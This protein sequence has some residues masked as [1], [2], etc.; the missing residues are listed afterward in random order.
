[1]V[2]VYL[3]RTKVCRPP[4]LKECMY[5]VSGIVNPNGHFSKHIW[6]GAGP[7]GLQCTCELRWYGY[8]VEIITSRTLS[9]RKTLFALN[10]TNK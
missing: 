5:V 2:T 9:V 7:E 8:H 3:A 6:E 1:M 10:F 4:Y